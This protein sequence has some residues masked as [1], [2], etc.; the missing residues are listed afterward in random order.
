MK[1]QQ[2][3][4]PSPGFLKQ[5]AANEVSPM[6]AVKSGEILADVR[7]AALGAAN[8]SGKASDV[9][10]SVEQSGK[11]DTNTLSFT[12]DVLINGTS[13]LTTTPVIAHVSG[14]ASTNKT[15]KVSGDTGITQAIMDQ[16]NNTVSLGDM[17]TYALTLT[18]TATPTTEMRNAAIVVEF[19]PAT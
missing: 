11:D 13:C 15:T 17:I 5:M 19:E 7:G 6:L 2:G 8:V 10:L 4:F 18:R 14:E 9:W 16:D 12:V 1:Q 3:P